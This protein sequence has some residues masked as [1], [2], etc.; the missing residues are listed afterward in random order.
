MYKFDAGAMFEAE[1]LPHSPIVERRGSFIDVYLKL[2]RNGAEWPDDLPEPGALVI[3]RTD[4]EPIDYVALNE[5]CD[6]EY[7]FT[8]LEKEQLKRYVRRERLAEKAT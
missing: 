4:G 3:C 2:R 7:R 5:G 6:C 1:L 8:E